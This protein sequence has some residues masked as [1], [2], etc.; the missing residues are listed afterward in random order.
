MGNNSTWTGPGTFTTLNPPPANDLC[1]NAEVVTCDNSYPGTTA[2]ATWDDVG[3]CGTTNTQP[4]V[5]YVFT[6]IGDMV[7]ADLCGTHLGYQ[8][9]CI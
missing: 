2:D 3:T 8:T 6:G 9:W 1:A 5:W 4:G 7:S